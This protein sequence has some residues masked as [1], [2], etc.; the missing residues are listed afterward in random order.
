MRKLFS[1]LLP[2]K[3]RVLAGIGALLIVD[4]AQLVV[5]LIVRAAID[6]LAV[7]VATPLLLLKYA[8]LVI[9]IAVVVAVFRFF[10][11]YLII[12]VARKVEE[13]LRNKIYNH[14]LKLD[15]Y[16]FS[17][18]RTG[19]I[20]A[21]LTN[22]IDAIRMSIGIGLVASAD[23][24]I[25][26][27]FA[28]FFMISLSPL[29]TLY[30]MLPLIPLTAVVLG[31]GRMIHRRFTRVQEAFSLLTEK[32]REFISGIR[33]IKAFVQE[34]GTSNRFKEVNEY[35]IKVNMELVKVWG[36]FNPLIS[37][38][39]GSSMALV[40]LLG[41]KKVLYGDITLGDFAAFSSYLG[42]MAWPMMAIGWVVNLMQRGTASLK[43]IEKILS[44][45]PN[46]KDDREAREYR[47]KGEI[48][49]KSLNFSYN[50]RRIL[51]DISFK[52]EAG[53]T[54]GIIGKTGSGKSTLVHLIPRIYDPPLDT[55]YI[56]GIELHRIKLHSLRSQI[57]FVPQDGFLFQDTI[58]ENVAFGKPDATDEEII[59][60]LKIAEIFDEIDNFP[61]GIYTRIGER[62]VTLS[63]GQK[64]RIALARAILKNPQILILDDALSQVDAEKE[65]KIMQNLKKL[66][67]GKTNIVISHRVSAI[68]D[69]DLILVMDGGRIVERGLHEELIARMGLYR[70]FYE[71]QQLAE[72]KL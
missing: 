37:L 19:D 31:F 65:E 71:L 11:R 47:I 38:L 64:Q 55:V 43:R 13:K 2:Y 4:L 27:L 35:F 20:M 8:L 12:G 49:I 54:L 26:A 30:T 3:K 29:L 18:M 33:V 39:A 7:G 1:F 32:V 50:G 69:S 63:G 5:P 40:L 9:L 21:H 22:D 16:F 51:Q 60:V 62:G 10:W 46:I 42:M 41:G 17:K 59:N 57:G 36:L 23:A 14:L 52:I 34:R 25:I 28:L 61:D 45:G 15:S 48:E 67:M 53:K 56:D 58:R 6:R 68:K 70:R 66:R 44:T 72:M 24:I